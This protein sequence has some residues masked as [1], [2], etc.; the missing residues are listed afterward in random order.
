MNIADQLPPEIA[1]QLHPERRK[2]EAQ[3]WVRRDELLAQYEGQWVGF[4]DD[5]VIAVGASPVEVFEAAESTGRH[6]FI[7]C[8]GKEDQ[9][10]RIRRTVSAYDSKY[11]GEPLPS[12]SVE[13]RRTTDQAGATFDRVIPDT[14][15]D[16]SVLPWGDCERL[17]LA[18]ADGV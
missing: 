5:Q 6:P 1:R 2:N 7:I 11:A 13:F 15:A 12:M 14:G 4:A 8:V 9:P 17:R 3:Y 10:C 16:A 18:P